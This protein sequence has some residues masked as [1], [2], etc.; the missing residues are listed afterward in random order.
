MKTMPARDFLMMLLAEITDE[1]QEQPQ[2]KVVKK[3]LNRGMR[4]HFDEVIRRGTNENPDDGYDDKC[5]F[6]LVE[7]I[8][9]CQA[10]LKPDLCDC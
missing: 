8:S 1:E 10:C 4:E 2:M 5:W 3:L 9:N 6:K 7:L